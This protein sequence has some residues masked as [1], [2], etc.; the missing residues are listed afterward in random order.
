CKI[1]THM[2]L[3]Q[4]DLR[5]FGFASPA[6]RELY[7][8]L[9]RISG[10]GP[11]SALSI[12]STLPIPTFVKAIERE[13]SALLTKVPGIGM[14]SAQRLIIELK[15]KLRHLMDYA[16]PGQLGVEEDKV[17]EVENALQTLGFSPKDVR[18]EL[19]LMGEEAQAQATEQ[20]IKEVIR[21]LYQR[22]R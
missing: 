8:Q 21:R 22:S 9:N 17:T 13:E 14:K 2:H 12:I 20:L 6:E 15:G 19:S 16:E 7:Q 11:K 3:A 5:L 4:D 10:V 1:Y 18:R